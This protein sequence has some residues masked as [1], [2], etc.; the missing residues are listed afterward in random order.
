VQSAVFRLENLLQF[1]PPNVHIELVKV[2]EGHDH[3]DLLTAGHFLPNLPRVVMQLQDLP[4][5]HPQKSYSHTANSTA[6]VHKLRQKGLHLTCCS[7]RDART[8]A[9]ECYF[10]RKS[11]LNLSASWHPLWHKREATARAACS[12]YYDRNTGDPSVG[13]NPWTVPMCKLRTA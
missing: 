2:Y 13:K 4:L 7:C 3:M 11:F 9:V 5:T 1:L 8:F 12:T 6:A 10:G